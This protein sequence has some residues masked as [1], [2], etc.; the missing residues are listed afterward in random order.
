MS[1]WRILLHKLYAMDSLVY[2]LL[3]SMLVVSGGNAITGKCVVFLL[4]NLSIL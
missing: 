1:A 3:L 2:I 4:I